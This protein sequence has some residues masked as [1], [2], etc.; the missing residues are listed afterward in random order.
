MYI[1]YSFSSPPVSLPIVCFLLCFLPPCL[2]RSVS[3]PL[4]LIPFYSILPFLAKST[5]L[6]VSFPLCLHPALSSSPLFYRPNP[7]L[8]T[9][10]SSSP[11]VSFRLI[12]FLSHLSPPPPLSLPPFFFPCLVQIPLFPLIFPCALVYRFLLASPLFRQQY[13]TLFSQFLCSIFTYFFG[14]PLNNTNFKARKRLEI[15]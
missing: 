8:A 12:S 14:F 7:F 3:F 11:Y 10:P 9:H 4:S 2:S 5:F 6:L 15:F 1:L 13:C